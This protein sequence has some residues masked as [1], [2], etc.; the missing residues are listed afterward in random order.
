M[1]SNKVS[2]LTIECIFEDL[3]LFDNMTIED[4]VKINQG[5]FEQF[6]NFVNQAVMEIQNKGFDIKKIHSIERIGGGT[7]IPAV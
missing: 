7:R 4:Y 2:P 3:D 6:Q 1:S 5:V